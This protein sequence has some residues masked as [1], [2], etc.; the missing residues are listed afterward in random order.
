MR[1]VTRTH[2]ARIN[3]CPTVGNAFM[4]SVTRPFPVGNGFMRSVTRTFP[5]GN[6]FIRSVTRT[7]ERSIPYGTY[8]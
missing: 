7:P 2:T 8:F 1:S 5:V 6:G 4:R 3:P